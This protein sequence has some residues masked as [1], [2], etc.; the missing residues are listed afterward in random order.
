VQRFRP[1]RIACTEAGEWRLLERQRALAAASALP[2]ALH[3]DDRFLCGHADFARWAEGRREL[4][5][6][7]F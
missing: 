7:H 1:A 5:M 6:E 2:V 3:E 4:R